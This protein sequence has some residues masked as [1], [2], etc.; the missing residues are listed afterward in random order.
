M[1]AWNRRRSDRSFSMYLR[2]SFIVVAPMQAIS[3]RESAGFR[4]FAASRDPSAEPAPMR[5]W[6]SSMKMMR[7]WF[8]RSSFRIPFRRSSNWP[9]YFVPATM[10]ERSIA[11]IFLLERKSGTA[12]STI[13]WA[14]PS[15][16]AV[17]PTPG[18]PRRIGLFFVRRERIWMIRST[19]ASRPTRGSNVPWAARAVRS[20]AYS[21]RNGSSFFCLEVSRSLMRA[22][23]SSRTP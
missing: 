19:S 21:A 18:S 9:R 13:R 23:V 20:R 4:M 7:S 22:I 3:P 6:I 11:R 14:R 16:I 8:S 1:I 17:F 5:E 12:P 15:T 10:R 2:Y